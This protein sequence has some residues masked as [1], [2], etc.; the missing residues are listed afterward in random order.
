MLVSMNIMQLWKIHPFFKYCLSIWENCLYGTMQTM[1][2]EQ[3]AIHFCSECETFL[4]LGKEQNV[5]P[6][7]VF[8]LFFVSTHYAR[9]L[10]ECLTVRITENQRC[11][12]NRNNQDQSSIFSH[13][14]KGEVTIFCIVLTR[15]YLPSSSL[16]SLPHTHRR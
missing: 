9:G 3:T 14:G 8:Y 13:K 16:P 10:F 2:L 6:P 1:S 15:F 12:T 5:I 4:K 7:N 11:F